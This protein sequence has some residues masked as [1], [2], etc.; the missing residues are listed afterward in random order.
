M[1]YFLSRKTYEPLFLGFSSN[2]SSSCYSSSLA[3]KSSFP[4]YSFSSTF[5]SIREVIFMLE[6]LYRGRLRGGRGYFTL[7][8]NEKRATFQ[9]IIIGCIKQY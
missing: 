6:D 8:G 2:N 9:T 1:A 7:G 5:A 3:N 4:V